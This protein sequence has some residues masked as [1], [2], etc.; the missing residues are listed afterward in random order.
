MGYSAQAQLSQDGDFI[1]RVA[2]CAAIEIDDKTKQPLQWALD[3]SWWLAAAPGFADAYQYAIDNGNPRPGNDPAV[4]TDGMILGAVQ[5]LE[6]EQTQ[7]AGQQGQ[8]QEQAQP[9]EPPAEE[10]PPEETPKA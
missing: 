3:N 6:T 1:N 7:P 5:A 2:A 9:E 4:I 8:Q 10:S